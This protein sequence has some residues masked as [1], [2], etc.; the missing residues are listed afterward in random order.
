MDDREIICDN[1]ICEQKLIWTYVRNYY[2]NR[3]VRAIFQ[4]TGIS[5]QT[6]F[7]IFKYL[8]KKKATCLWMTERLYVITTYE[9]KLIWT[10]M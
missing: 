9:Q 10:H 8:I 4:V 3:Q 7:K 6:S 2:V 1:H 5:I